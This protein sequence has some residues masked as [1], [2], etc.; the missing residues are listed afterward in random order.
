MKTIDHPVLSY[1]ED[2]EL[3]KMMN[4]PRDIC[5]KYGIN[6]V[7]LDGVLN[8]SSGRS[9]SFLYKDKK[10]SRVELIAKQY[11]ENQGY[12]ASWNEGASFVLIRVAMDSEIIRRTKHLIDLPTTKESKI[13]NCEISSWEDISKKGWHTLASSA[14]GT[15]ANI[16]VFEE[17]KSNPKISSPYLTLENLLANASCVF[18]TNPQK[19]LEEAAIAL[20][21]MESLNLLEEYKIHMQKYVADKTKNDKHRQYIN[22]NEW[23][24][25]HALKLIEI[26][27][28]NISGSNLL[29]HQSLT[30][31]LEQFDLSLI[32]AVNRKMKFVEVKNN[33]GF[34][35]FQIVA[36][37]DWLKHRNQVT[38]DF[39]I[40]FV[41]PKNT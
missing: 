26:F 28:I 19:F 15:M 25:E 2:L 37:D 5:E 27:G 17:A 35:P 39:E 20:Y 13:D 9:N 7:E 36:L 4:K 31:S 40:C 23:S 22:Y 29:G 12:I 34:T 24:I 30:G 41:K 8:Q 3:I 11:Y 10:Y 21:E 6:F 33:D 16:K 1:V 32:D 38:A 14:R 18:K